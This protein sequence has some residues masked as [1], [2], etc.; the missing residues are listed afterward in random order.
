MEKKL[1]ND[2]AK[3]SKLINDLKELPKENVPDNFE[4]NLMTRI[5]N[6]NFGELRPERTIQFNF[7]RF[8][9]PS[10]V[11]I[12]AIIIFFLVLPESN[13]QI[14]NPLMTDPPIISEQI[15]QAKNDSESRTTN[16]S[17]QKSNVQMSRQKAT[18]NMVVK[19]NDVVEDQT[20]RYPINRNRSV[21]LDDYI[22]GSNKNRTNLRQ[23]SV[24]GGAD[25]APEFDG[26]LMRQDADAE[27]IQKYRLM[28]DSL[29]KVQEREDSL[30]KMVK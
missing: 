16:L 13:Q 12:T 3:F 23:G 6:R 22:S 1:Y 21:S 5:Q 9:A 26:F 28:M 14:E 8:F 18:N 2:E 15:D 24:V 17:A 25:E 7:V 20:I 11:V 19:P 4:Y 27:T 30:K 29:K 10:A